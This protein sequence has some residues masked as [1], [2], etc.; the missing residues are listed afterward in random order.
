MDVAKMKDGDDKKVTGLGV[1][2]EKKMVL[3]PEKKMVLDPEKKMVLD[4]NKK[5]V[6]DPKKK[7]VVNRSYDE[8]LRLFERMCR[9]FCLEEIEAAGYTLLE[10]DKTTT[11]RPAAS[12]S[13]KRCQ[14]KEEEEQQQEEEIEVVYDFKRPKLPLPPGRPFVRDGDVYIL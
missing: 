10:D 11:T 4:P 5:M 6:L 2:L 7:M 8:D 9:N 14:P 3:D 13:A 12:A 1:D